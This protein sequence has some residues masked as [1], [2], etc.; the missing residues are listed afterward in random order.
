MTR[1]ELLQAIGDACKRLDKQMV[2]IFEIYTQLKLNRVSINSHT[3]V[4]MDLESLVDEDGDDCP[5]VMLHAGWALKDMPDEDDEDDE[6]C[7]AKASP[8]PEDEEAEVAAV[9]EY[10]AVEFR[11]KLEGNFVGRSEKPPEP[12]LQ[13]FKVGFCM[14]VTYITDDIIFAKSREEARGIAQE[15]LEIGGI[16]CSVLDCEEPVE[17][18][19]ILEVAKDF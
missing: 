7:L 2:T 17:L 12:E 16:D 18:D 1:E 13:R 8:M 4:I 15:M 5:A 19:Y 14:E 3:D 9:I 11:E 10:I 6:E